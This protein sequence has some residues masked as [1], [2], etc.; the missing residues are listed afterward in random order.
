MERKIQRERARLVMCI[1]Q[2]TVCVYR[3]LLLYYINQYELP[4]MLS[5]CCPEWIAM[6]GWYVADVRVVMSLQENIG[7]RK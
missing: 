4:C 2:L 6:L 7:E 3:Q 1:V 5:R